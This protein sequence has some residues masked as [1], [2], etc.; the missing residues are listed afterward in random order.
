MSG[1]GNS[2]VFARKGQG[3]RGNNYRGNYRTKIMGIT[4]ITA[5]TE[6][7]VKT[8]IMVIIETIIARTE[9]T[10]SII[11]VVEIIEETLMSA[12][13]RQFRETRRHL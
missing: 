7:A 5:T 12:L 13:P 3:Y 9:I 4:K 10:T 1:N 6:I 8:K 2:I 11:E